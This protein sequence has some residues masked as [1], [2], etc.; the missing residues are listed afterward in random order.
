MNYVEI[1]E[2]IE[3]WKKWQSLSHYTMPDF[4]F[5]EIEKKISFQFDFSQK[6]FMKALYFGSLENFAQVFEGANEVL[7]EFWERKYWNSIEGNV[8][9]EV[10]ECV[11]VE[12]ASFSRIRL[13]FI[14]N[15]FDIYETYQMG[16]SGFFYY[17]CDD[18][19][20]LQLALEIS[21]DYGMALLPV[22]LNQKEFEN[23][24]ETDSSYMAFLC[25][26]HY[27]FYSFWSWASCRIPQNIKC[28]ALVYEKDMNSL[29]LFLQK[30]KFV[31]IF[32]LPFL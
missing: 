28:F 25:L 4:A 20:L 27:D 22:C 32:Y 17:G 19:I 8:F 31:K 7:S 26:N 30:E 21:R 29:K 2:K 23:I 16:F 1:F 5:F 15:S 13:D 12:M 6:A 9:F 14:S 18:F 11:K 24:L 3:E 10:L